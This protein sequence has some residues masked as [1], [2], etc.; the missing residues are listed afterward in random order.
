MKMPSAIVQALAHRSVDNLRKATASEASFV[1]SG[2]RWQDI[3]NV[4]TYRRRDEQLE[5]S[6]HICLSVISLNIH[7]KHNNT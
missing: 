7:M 5:L 6:A 4:E 3:D 2:A 1:A